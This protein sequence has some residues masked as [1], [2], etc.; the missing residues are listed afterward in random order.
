MSQHGRAG[1]AYTI[2]VFFLT[3]IIAAALM[4]VF[5]Q[6]INGFLDVAQSNSQTQAASDG[7]GYVAAAWTWFPAFVMIMA[8]VLMISSAVYQSNQ[9]G[10]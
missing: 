4:A 1:L 5:N 2:V 3:I 6:P 10:I 9:G 8:A 7:I